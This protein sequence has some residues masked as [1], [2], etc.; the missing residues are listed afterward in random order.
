MAPHP[1]FGSSSFKLVAKGL[2]ELHRLIKE[3]KDDSSEADS[4]RDALDAPLKVLSRIEKERAQWLSD[5]LY[6]VSEPSAT[7]T[8]KDMNSQAQQQLHEAFEARQ[9]REWDRALTLVRR[10]KEYISPALL[11]Y[12]RGAIWLEAGYSEVASVFYEHAAESDPENV[13][14]RAIYMHALAV[15]NPDAARKLANAILEDDE[16]NAPVVVARAADIRF[17]ETKTASDAASAQLY[18]EL[19]PILAKN[20]TRI[21]EDE[22]TAS[23]AS[24]YAMTVALLGF[25]HEFLGNTGA[26]V[27]CYSRGL[28]TNPDNDGLLVARGI[29]LYGASPH[30]ISDLERAA[31]LGSP[32]VWPYL[33]LAHHYLISGQ[34]ERCRMMCETGLR[35]PGS[36]AA[37]SQIEEWRAIAQAELGFPPQ[38]VRV[39]F[40][41]AVRLD[42]S[43]ELAKRNQTAF[44]ASLKA[45]T[46][47]QHTLWEQKSVTAVR[48]FGLAER[49]YS[50][51]A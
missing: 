46:M 34:F 36:D 9:S 51:A 19:I 49:R 39:A 8:Q 45:A 4:V 25:C 50:F 5:D 28:H 29:L 32:V 44:E 18:R 6:S 10:W 23:R 24:A 35:M 20:M 2:V 17:N 42:P 48:Q 38:A 13:N 16:K 47:R 15:S 12:I 3:E 40:E 37:K 41:A 27:N 30:A 11:S 7:A 14:Y 43:N 1:T 21:E 26:A 31:G 33:Y 22:G